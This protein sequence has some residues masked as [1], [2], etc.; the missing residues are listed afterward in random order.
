MNLSHYFEQNAKANA[1]KTKGNSEL[2]EQSKINIKLAHY[3]TFTNK[4]NKFAN[5]KFIDMTEY[6]FMISF[7]KTRGTIVDTQRYHVIIN[8]ILQSNID[9]SDKQEFTE[10]CHCLFKHLYDLYDNNVEN[11][12]NVKADKLIADI[13]E[14]NKNNF[15]FTNDQKNA[16]K[17]LCY[18]LY[19]STMKTF[20]LYGFAGTGK[21]TTITKLIHYLLYKNYVN[22]IVFTAPTNKAV[23]VIKSKF[24]SDLDDLVKNKFKNYVTEN[25]S[26]D[27]ILDKL[28]DKGFKIN[29][30]TIHKLL[31]YQNDFDIEG[32]RIFIK[33]DKASIDNYDLVI[34]DESSMIPFQIVT[35]LFEQA[36]RKDILSKKTP[37]VLFIGDLA[38]LPPV[39]ESISVVFAK[40]KL[41]FDF[42]L[43]QNAYMN[44]SNKSAIVIDDK[45]LLKSIEIKFNELVNNV[46]SMKYVVLKEVMR[47]ND[48]NVIGICNEVRASVLNEIKFPIFHKF[49][50]NKVFLYK[51][52]KKKPKT[53]S[54]W[55]TKAIEYFSSIDEKQ[56]LSNIILTWTNRQTDNYNET[57]RKILYKK[58]ILNKFEIGDILILT[59][60]YNIKDAETNANTNI[61]K[62]IKEKE[63]NRFYTS[64]QIKVTDI[65]HVTKAISEFSESLNKNCKIKN[66]NDIKEKYAKVIKLI[67]KNTIRK[68]DVWKLH[69]HKLADIVTNTIPETHQIYVASDNSLEILVKDRKYMAERIKE[70][71]TYYKNMHKENLNVIDKN[72]IRPLWKELNKKLVEP[73]AKVN[74]GAGITCHRSQGSSFYNVFVDMDDIFKN[75]NLNEAKRCLYTAIT[76]TVNELHILI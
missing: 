26:F 41:D 65:E 15:S 40:N 20:G 29:F 7:V 69:V 50:G 25:E 59:D 75:Q 66:E 22:S 21:T 64:E 8:K 55:Y 48:N 27:D 1:S 52:D 13:E 49:S 54:E 57:M 34:V 47:S 3:K 63:S 43:F 74:F 35:H 9:N 30:L 76:R 44:N 2:D 70:L 67:N 56:H 11:I 19:D 10:S 24:R 28:E 18:F 12:N 53:S 72:I 46:L 5:S 14:Y 73:F 6:T 45:E 37:K 31:N 60:F 36:N 62:S 16:I 4:M 58:N 51:Y 23:N 39:N 17:N 32:E 71:R 33:G 42:K 38:Q 61:K 68:Y